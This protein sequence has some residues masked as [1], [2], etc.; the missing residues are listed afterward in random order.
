MPGPLGKAPALQSPTAS[1]TQHAPVLT[2]LTLGGPAQASVARSGL[3]TVQVLSSRVPRMMSAEG[4]HHGQE[5][6]CW[7]MEHQEVGKTLPLMS[8]SVGPSVLCS[9]RTT[10]GPRCL[11]LSDPQF[12]PLPSSQSLH[13]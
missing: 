12:L 2:R 8:L 6:L 5:L 3:G 1:P 10:A 4:G 13:L 7:P 11:N 9:P